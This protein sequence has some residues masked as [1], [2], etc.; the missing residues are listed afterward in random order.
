VTLA[1]I[2]L[3]KPSPIT[4]GL[5]QLDS[6]MQINSD[7][8]SENKAEN[9]LKKFEYEL[10]PVSMLMTNTAAPGLKKASDEFVEPSISTLLQ[11]NDQP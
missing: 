8:K 1:S 7:K 5:L 10:E 3:N 11:Q 2:S 6:D 4:V 9:W